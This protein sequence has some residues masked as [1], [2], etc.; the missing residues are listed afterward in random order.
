MYP[1]RTRSQGPGSRRQGTTGSH[2]SNTS[3]GAESGLLLTADEGTNSIIAV[4]DAR[5]LTQI[6]SLIA[7]LDVRRPQVMVE[8]LVISL[9]DADAINL[10]V[11]I[12][13]QL[14]L[15]DA[16]M[17]RLSSLFGL[18]TRGANGDREAADATGFTGL[19]LNPGD[20]SV[21]IH[22]LEQLN[23]GRSLSTPRILVNSNQSA[24]FNSVLQQPLLATNASSTVATTSYGGTSDAGTSVTVKPQIAEGDHLVLEY[25]IEL[26]SFVGSSSTPG[27]PP[28]RQTNNVSSNVTLPDGFTV[29][30]GGL[31]LTSETNATSQVPF[32]GSIPIIGEAFKNRANSVS[33]SRFF[34]FIRASV[35]RHAEFEDLKYLSTIDTRAAGID[36]GWPE[37]EPRVIR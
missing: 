11:E 1:E 27:L 29:V 28:P 37:L 2:A 36:D 32:I 16:V 23:H 31:E 26:S 13:K 25:R 15:T 17:G 9:S 35:Q 18:S 6:E 10:G 12:E 24:V 5:L 3:K 14:N 33:H 4:G 20:F 7:A 19:V 21:V 8:A 22:A 34:V 30:V